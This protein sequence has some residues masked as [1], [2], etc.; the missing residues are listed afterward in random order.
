M[1]KV[2]RVLLFTILKFIEIIG[3]VFIPFH[4]GKFYYNLKGYTFGCSPVEHWFKGIMCTFFLIAVV[5]SLIGILVFVTPAFIN[6]NWNVVK[7]IVK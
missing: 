1:K 6:A 2:L 5:A 7:K 4:I 3:I